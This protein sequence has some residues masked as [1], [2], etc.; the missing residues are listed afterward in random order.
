VR[1]NYT[2]FMLFCKDVFVQTCQREI[3]NLNAT[4]QKIKVHRS[5]D[6]INLPNKHIKEDSMNQ[7]HYTKRESFTQLT[8]EQRIKIETLIQEHHTQEYIANFINV[9]K[10]TISREIKRGTSTRKDTYHRDYSYYSAKTAQALADQ[11]NTNSHKKYKFDLC[12]DFIQHVRIYLLKHKWSFDVIAGYER[13]QKHQFSTSV[14][15]KTLYNYFHMGLLNLRPIDLPDMVNRRTYTK[16]LPKRISKGKSIDLRPDVVNQRAE[17]GHWEIDTVIG[18]R[19]KSPVLLTLVERVA[20]FGLIFKLPSKE[21][22]SVIHIIDQLEQSLS[23]GFSS[24]FKTITSD[25]GGEF[26][27]FEKLETSILFPTK[28]RCLQYFAHPYAS[29]ER[30]SNEHGNK[31]IR[32][33]FPKKTDF[34]NVS[35]KDIQKVQNKLNH[36]PRKILGYLSAYQYIQQYI[37]LNII[38]SMSFTY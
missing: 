9:D 12:S 20:R 25:N 6:I 14:C 34:I 3:V 16:K 31:R 13:N 5:Y 19:E 30:G 26:Q 32:R 1:L 37:P 11:R 36:T 17:F 8:Y 4:K 27:S 29:Y 15:S 28:Q 22:S 18:K 35:T 21:S 10:S 33:F 38:S 24:V 2:T 23:T 7:S